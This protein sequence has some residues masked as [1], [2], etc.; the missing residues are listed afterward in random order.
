MRRIEKGILLFVILAIAQGCYYDNE[1][2]LY[3][4]LPCDVTNSSFGA[5]INPII[6]I[7][8]TLGGCHVPGTGRVDF[9][10]YEGIKSVVDDGR[11]KQ[12]VIDQKSMPPSRPLS[13]CNIK[14]IQAWID[15]G[16][17]NN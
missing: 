12:M 13:T 15:N 6:Q 3:P 9:T 17:L 11:L 1:E 8:C 5:G 10:T 4:Q 2:T 7:N 14:L 16:A